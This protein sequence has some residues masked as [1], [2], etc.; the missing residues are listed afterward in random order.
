MKKTKLE[1]DIFTYEHYLE[2]IGGISLAVPLILS[3]LG[4]KPEDKAVVQK[5]YRDLNKENFDGSILDYLCWISTQYVLVEISKKIPEKNP[6]KYAEYVINNYKTFKSDIRNMLR[7][8]NR[9]PEHF[10]NWFGRV[11]MDCYRLL[12]GYWFQL[13][14]QDKNQASV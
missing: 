8:L 7:L 10:F 1:M 12:V 3:D 6:L 14:L 13:Y 5:C 11:D 2:H 9:K 4:N